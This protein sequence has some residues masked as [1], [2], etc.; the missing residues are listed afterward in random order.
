MPILNTGASSAPDRANGAGGMLATLSGL[1]SRVIR[2]PQGAGL[3]PAL[4]TSLSSDN[5]P[6]TRE[7]IARRSRAE[8]RSHK[9]SSIYEGTH[10]RLAREMQA[11][12]EAGL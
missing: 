10:L 6:S 3:G 2:L 8:R 7:L 12:R 11:I 9:D 4:S 5:E 1:L